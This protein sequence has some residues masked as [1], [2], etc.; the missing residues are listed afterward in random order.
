MTMKTVGDE[1]NNAPVPDDEDAFDDVCQ[2]CGYTRVCACPSRNAL[3]HALDEE[4]KRALPEFNAA[5]EHASTLTFDSMLKSFEAA[6]DEIKKLGDAPMFLKPTHYV[7]TPEQWEEIRNGAR[8]V[9]EPPPG[10]VSIVVDPNAGM[11]G[12]ARFDFTPGKVPSATY[13]ITTYE[14]NL[15]YSKV[16]RDAEQQ[17][18]DL[19]A[20]HGINEARRVFAG[21]EHEVCSD[22]E[23]ALNQAH[24]MHVRGERGTINGYGER[25]RCIVQLCEYESCREPKPHEIGAHGCKYHR[26]STAYQCRSTCTPLEI[27]GAIAEALGTGHK[28]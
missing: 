7:V 2:G 26:E 27:R 18:I 14:I 23:C 17:K 21:R 8:D 9:P 15:D 3:E 12:P 28:R 25:L 4:N 11:I 13:E 19:L 20:E 6:R 5:L 10:G 16:P 22:T 24:V 1:A